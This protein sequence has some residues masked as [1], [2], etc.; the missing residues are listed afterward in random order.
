[1]DRKILTA[2][3]RIPPDL[4]DDYLWLQKCYKHSQETY[5]EHTTPVMRLLDLVRGK[6]KV[7]RVN[8]WKSLENVWVWNDAVVFELEKAFWDDVSGSENWLVYLRKM[9]V[10]DSKRGR[11]LGSE[12][13][14]S[15]QQWCEI[16]G[17][18]VC[19]VSLPF[20]FSRDAYS[21]GAYF[22][23]KAADV[24]DLW[25]E[26]EFHRLMGVELLRSWYSDRG[27]RNAFLLDGHFF[28]FSGAINDDD[29]FIYVP[30]TLDDSAKPLASHRL[31]KREESRTESV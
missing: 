6:C 7:A 31:H 29:Q 9:Y 12:F 10:V 30:G 27:F 14:H 26:G 13:V 20:G 18:A 1:M 28:S 15:L 21:G 11:G 17:S 19:L 23:D 2:N 16:S 5:A 4:I 25:E 22:L 3:S 8:G 24:V